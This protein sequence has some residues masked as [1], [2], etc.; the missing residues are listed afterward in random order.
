MERQS[1]FARGQVGDLEI[2]PGDSMP[3]TGT[4]SFHPC[5]FGGK[6]GSIALVAVGL[7]LHISDLP[8]G[9]NPLYELLAE[10]SDGLANAI[11]LRQIHSGTNDHL[12]SVP[13]VVMVS[14]PCLTPLVLIKASATLRTSADL[15]RTTRTSRQ[16][17]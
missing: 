6:A 3:P 16:L 9:V 11:D 5:L 13:E 2:L 8:W 12:N 15:P 17:S 1:G 10:A 7:T 4:D 14:R